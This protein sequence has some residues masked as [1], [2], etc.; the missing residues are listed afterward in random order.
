MSKFEFFF[1]FYSLLLGLGLAE[2]LQGVASIVRS[3]RVRAIGAETALAAVGLL[4]IIVLTWLDAWSTLS[5]VELSVG[6][7]AGPLLVSVCYY[8]AAVIV[9]PKDIE[10]WP[11]LDD[12]YS[13]RKRY[14][15]GLLLI[16][17]IVIVLF[18]FPA[19]FSSEAQNRPTEFWTRV[20]PLEAG[21]IGALGALLFVR[22]RA[23]NIAGWL[24]I[25]ALFTVPH[26]NYEKAALPEPPA[27]GARPSS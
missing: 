22:G 13:S 14:V 8:L 1:G 7:I 18:L 9:F 26:W 3:Q 25:I 27:A 17:E 20:V 12:Y 11:S 4:C 21:V 24:V 23:L 10:A 15:I 16:A 5:N 2:L 6:F 19:W